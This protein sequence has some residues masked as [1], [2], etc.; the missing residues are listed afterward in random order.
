MQT[1]M[2]F[3][4]LKLKALVPLVLL[5]PFLLLATELGLIDFRD[6]VDIADRRPILIAHRGGVITGNSHE[7]S[8]TAIRLAAQAGY[9]MVELDV[10]K[11]SDGVPIVFHDRTLE[12]A[13][14]K[15]G[16]VMDFSASELETFGYLNGDDHIMRLEQ[17]LLSCRRLKLGVMLDLKAGRDSQ[18][19]LEKIDN[20]LVKHGLANST[21]SFS[22]S[23]TARRYLK[24]V[25]FTP[26][27]DEMLRLRAGENLDLS[28]RF[29]FG[30]PN[31]L[32]PGDIVRL[33]SA[34]A[35]IIPAINTFRYPSEN[36]F[37]LAQ[38]DIKQLME[39][40]VDGFQID[41]VYFPFFQ[42]RKENESSTEQNTSDQLR[43]KNAVNP[44]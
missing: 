41:S 37:K 11:S 15:G 30:L 3:M 33:K 2:N 23:D 38:S 40:G 10:Q 4:F 35:L 19:F 6:G 32:Q 43:S 9:D 14:G 26:T 7:C 5:S 28:R 22:G 16:R 8:L 25:S 42:N 17:A 13:C 44:E 12:K 21:I 24:H 1:T 20:L 31:Q 39:E 27:E 36:H 18:A 34:G 29:W